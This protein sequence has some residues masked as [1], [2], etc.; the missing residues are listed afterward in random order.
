MKSDDWNWFLYSN[1]YLKA[2]PP[3]NSRIIERSGTSVGA[4]VAKFSRK[5]RSLR[6]SLYEFAVGLT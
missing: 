4:I 3:I 2:L 1:Q 5:E 6:A